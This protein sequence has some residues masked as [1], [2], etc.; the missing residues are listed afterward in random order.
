M[1]WLQ[2]EEA[3]NLPNEIAAARRGPPAHDLGVER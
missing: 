3:L 2:P 1:G